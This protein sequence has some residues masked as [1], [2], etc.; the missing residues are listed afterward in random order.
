MISK[1]LVSIFITHQHLIYLYLIYNNFIV[2]II[3][4]KGVTREELNP[5][6]RVTPK[7]IEQVNRCLIAQ[8]KCVLAG[9]KNLPPAIQV[10]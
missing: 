9:G 8:S 7:I 6:N 3:R 1:I 2:K 5:H 4:Q 10:F